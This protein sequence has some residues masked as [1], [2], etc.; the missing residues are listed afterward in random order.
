MKIDASPPSTCS[1]EQEDWMSRFAPKSLVPVGYGTEVFALFQEDF[2]RL[3]AAGFS[4]TKDPVS[5]VIWSPSSTS[6]RAD[7]PLPSC[8]FSKAVGITESRFDELKRL[9]DAG[10]RQHP[11]YKEFE[12]CIPWLK[13]GFILSE[14]ILQKKFPVAQPLPHGSINCFWEGAGS[15]LGTAQYPS[16]SWREEMWWEH[17]HG[18]FAGFS[19]SIQNYTKDGSTLQTTPRAEWLKLAFRNC[20]KCEEARAGKYCTCTDDLKLK[21][22]DEVIAEHV[23][24]S[25]R[26]E[27]VPRRSPSCW[28]HNDFLR[29]I[30]KRKGAFEFL[31]LHAN[32]MCPEALFRDIT[33]KFNASLTAGG[34][35]QHELTTDE[36]LAVMLYSGNRCSVVMLAAALTVSRPNVFGLQR[37]PIK[38][39]VP[40]ETRKRVAAPQPARVRFEFPQAL[41]SHHHHRAT[42][43]APQ[44]LTHHA[45][46]CRP[47]AL[48]RH[49]RP[50]P[51]P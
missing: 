40:S 11:D 5:R 13:E 48:P 10:R 42:V 12:A 9:D 17:C 33:R 29:D 4:D 36:V 26:K 6:P 45:P 51:P 28:F 49:Q 20:R 8:T 21:P 47:L 46:A 32:A 14:N 19:F 1:K 44:D 2:E 15:R 23:M 35:A 38:K 34:A 18:Y 22:S 30:D 41:V 27:Q 37:A 25:S 16:R 7:D 3:K 24:L 39:P 50:S 43:S 31:K